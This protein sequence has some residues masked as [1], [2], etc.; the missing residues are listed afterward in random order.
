MLHITSLSQILIRQTVFIINE[1]VA[2]AT[3]LIVGTA[4]NRTL[5]VHTID[6]DLIKSPARCQ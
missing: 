3:H 6:L 4:G 5:V 1:M 2:A